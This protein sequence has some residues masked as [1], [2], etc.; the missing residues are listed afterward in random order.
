MKLRRTILIVGFIVLFFISLFV[1]V[2]SKLTIKALLTLDKE[3]WLI[4]SESRW[5]RTM[6]IVL[7][8]SSLAV[9]GLIMQSVSRNKFISPATSGTTDAAM[10]G[11][12]LSYLIVGSKTQLSKF[13]FAF[14]FAFLSAFIFIK[15]INR[16]KHRDI[17]YV[18]LLGIMYG[19]IL[20]AFASFIAM[21]TDSLDIINQLT[22]G[23][24]T[25]VTRGNYY[26]LLIV[27]VPLIMAFLYATKFSIVSA[28]EDFSL[29]LGVKYNKVLTVGLLIV[30]LIAATTFIAVGP[31]PFIG[32]IIPNIMS[33]FYGDN[34]KKSIVD[35]ALFGSIFV[36]INDIISRIIIY[37]NEVSISLTMGIIGAFIFLILIFKGAKEWIRQ[38]NLTYLY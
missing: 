7:A 14:G 2:S 17:V 21:S 18:P 19:G 33:K 3:A 13:I 10:L 36:L 34:V 15:F 22:H 25:A 24:F 11:I 30:A 9:A 35:V 23:S 27:I 12:L 16:L 28:G 31:L 29:N 20:A 37:P 32:L 38:R 5:P 1:G 26:M 8:A 6:A 4:F